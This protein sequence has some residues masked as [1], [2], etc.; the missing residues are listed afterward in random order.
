MK[1]Q[2]A[3]NTLAKVKKKVVKSKRKTPVKKTKRKT[4]KTSNTKGSQ[5]RKR[6]AH[7]LRQTRI[8]DSEDEDPDLTSASDSESWQ[9]PDNS[10][11]NKIHFTGPMRPPQKRSSPFSNMYSMPSVTT[12][13][14][15]TANPVINFSYPNIPSPSAIGGVPIPDLSTL[16]KLGAPASLAYTAMKYLLP[17]FPTLPSLRSL[18][19]S[20]PAMPNIYN[21]MPT[22]GQT[23][24]E[25]SLPIDSTTGQSPQNTEVQQLTY[26]PRTEPVTTPQ[27]MFN[28]PL[29]GNAGQ[30][31]GDTEPQLYDHLL[32]DHETGAA[33]PEEPDLHR[34]P[35]RQEGQEGW[36]SSM[37]RNLA[38]TLVGATLMRK[39]ATGTS[40]HKKIKKKNKKNK[41]HKRKKSIKVPLMPTTFFKAV[42]TY[43]P[44]Q[45]KLKK[46]QKTHAKPYGFPVLQ[47]PNTPDPLYSALLGSL[48][49]PL[50]HNPDPLIIVNTPQPPDFQ[51]QNV[52]SDASFLQ[53]PLLEPPPE[54]RDPDT[55]IQEPEF[56]HTEAWLSD[57]EFEVTA[58]GAASP[59]YYSER[60]FGSPLSALSPLFASPPES[61]PTSPPAMVRLRSPQFQSRDLTQLLQQIEQ[62]VSEEGDSVPISSPLLEGLEQPSLATLDPTS[63]YKQQLNVKDDNAM[64]EFVDVLR[65]Q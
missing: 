22:L 41:K 32:H 54:F 36:I 5:K 4:R 9:P 2:P 3:E 35:I 61:R 56:I 30:D 21:Y 19:P 10:L 58:D 18:M 64:A 13:P 6:S 7:N 16:L 23:R 45:N 53:P 60:D 14:T 51:S 25:P 26:E 49:R 44:D 12:N 11:L 55:D 40:R 59:E 29:T 33:H 28:E 47:Q 15:I 37:A 17:S 48:K 24:G 34:P 43:L 63:Y 52:T 57:D 39:R 46:K 1:Q 8:K 50:A 27:Q 31:S 38:T 62:R 42:S 65:R 20:M